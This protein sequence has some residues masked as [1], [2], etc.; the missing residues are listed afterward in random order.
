M[1]LGMFMHPIHDFK[2]GYHTL[3][4][5]DMEVIKCADE[6][7]FDEV[8]LGEHFAL[9]SEPIQ[10]PLMLMAALIPQTKRI[11]LCTGV[12][13]L[14][15]QHPAIVAG[16][17]AQF[18]HMAKGR[19]MMGIG[20]GATPPDFE[21][22]KLLDK[23]RMEM[24]EESIDC[25]HYIWA[26]DPPY[27]WH[28]K[29]WQ[30]EIKDNVLPNIGVGGMGKPFQKPYPPVMIPAMSPKSSSVRL[31]ARRDW[32]FISAN[33]VPDD[34]AI[35]HWTD[36]CDERKK[37]GKTPDGA[38]WRCGRTLLITETDAEAEAY[39]KTPKN[40]LWWY[41]HYIVTIMKFGGFHGL[42]KIDPSMPDDE[43]TEEY[44]IRTMVH[45]GSPKTVAK[46]IAA[47]RDKSGPFET[48]IVSHHDWVPKQ[49][50][51]RHME[52]IATELMP[53]LRAEVG[54]KDAAE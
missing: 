19:F 37:I 45:A 21:M 17:V 35:G 40:A 48:L 8:W 5:E 39:L 22:F 1:K 41:F 31:A 33:F 23:N 50:W 53:R 3:L 10:S 38:K 18:D 44:C 52:L 47:F 11:Q 9:P 12:L 4:N 24:V 29:H 7:G 25:I 15:Y 36:Y 49:M 28:G 42:L 20:P 2:R 32:T 51:R 16:Q 26:N 27:K 14:A 30:F 34:V 54:W 46:K 43:V 6:V 13:C